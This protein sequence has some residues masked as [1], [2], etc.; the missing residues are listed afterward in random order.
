[1]KRN[2]SIHTDSEPNKDALLNKIREIGKEVHILA[3]K[4]KSNTENCKFYLNI[5]K[6][7]SKYFS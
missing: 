4:I 2:N 6:S 7:F 3:E 5:S 1:M